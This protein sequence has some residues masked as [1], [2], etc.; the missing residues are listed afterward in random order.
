MSIT[1]LMPDKDLIKKV[2]E[3]LF[4]ELGYANA[5]R[6]LSLPK[7]EKVESVKRHRIWQDSLEKDKFFNDVFPPQ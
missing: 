2:T 7:E 3:I 1:K 6:Y 4:K 5:V